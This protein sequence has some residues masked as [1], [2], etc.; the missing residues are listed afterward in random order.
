MNRVIVCFL[1]LLCA[2]APGCAQT[3]LFPELA[4]PQAQAV[5][6]LSIMS[7]QDEAFEGVSYNGGYLKGRGCQPVSIANGVIAAFGVQDRQAA[8]AL[9]KE[10][11]QALVV[12]WKRGE[13]RMELGRME[14][15]LNAGDRMA[16]AEEFAQ[17]AELIGGY[18]GTITVTDKT[19]TADMAHEYFAGRQTGML[20]GRMQ[21]H[22]QRKDLLDVMHRLYEMDM[23]DAVVC[24]ASVGVGNEKS[25]A[26]LST[27][28]NGHYLTLMMYVD[29]F[30][31]EGCMYVL[32]SLPRALKGE[33][34]GS[35]LVL[36]Q[37]Y[38]FSQ[39]KT[40]FIEKFDARRIRDTVIELKPAL[41]RGWNE[42]TLEQKDKLLRPL[43]LFGP[44]IL[45]IAWQSEK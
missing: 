9:V 6:Q 10:A 13:S 3:L 27:G 37:P 23:K 8:V 42:A 14:T 33:E 43:T 32:D 26:P 31:E 21:V 15:L 5:Q 38:P 44:G 29:S 28:K 20:V 18:G 35:D 17:L 4:Q 2:F 34:S 36:R 25:G 7:Q 41:Q 12:P 19:V 30:I 11:T 24:L 45:T 39:K 1:C 40:G 22:P 16:E